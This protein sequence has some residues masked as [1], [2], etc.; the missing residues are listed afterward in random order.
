MLPRSTCHHGSSSISVCVIDPSLQLPL[1]FPST[2]LEDSP[3]LAVLDCD[4]VLFNATLKVGKGSGAD[5]LGLGVGEGNWLGNGSGVNT[6]LGVETE[7]GFETGLG[8]LPGSGV[9][10]TMGVALGEG[11]GV[12]AGAVVGNGIGCVTGLG[13][14]AGD[15]LVPPDSSGDDGNKPEPSSVPPPQ[16]AKQI[17]IAIV[18]ALVRKEP[19]WNK[20]IFVIR[21]GVQSVLIIASTFF[22][23]R[24]HMAQI[25]NTHSSEELTCFVLYVNFARVCIGQRA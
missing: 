19:V 7:M 17:A 13:E 3:P 2:A 8:V 23:L 11:E 9:T 6:G 25:M 22:T 20:L 4:V 5:G 15:G 10:L 1:V 21:H 24:F 18:L 16:L 12:T 14:V